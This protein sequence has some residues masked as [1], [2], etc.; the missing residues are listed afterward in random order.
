MNSKILEEVKKNAG[1]DFSLGQYLY[2]GMAMVNGHRACI[3]VAYKIE[4]CIKKARQFE[5]VDPNIKFTHINKVRVGEMNAM[6]K[7]FMD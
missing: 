5:A 7:F 4:Y 6:D 3:S 2:M 1:P